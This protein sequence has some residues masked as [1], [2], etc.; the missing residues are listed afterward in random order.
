MATHLLRLYDRRAQLLSIV[1]LL[2]LVPLQGLCCRGCLLLRR[3]SDCLCGR[4]LRT[5]VG[6]HAGMP[7]LCLLC[8]L[9]QAPI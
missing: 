8:L 9:L 1:R 5:Q 2:G 7:L 4:Q 6:C 3:F